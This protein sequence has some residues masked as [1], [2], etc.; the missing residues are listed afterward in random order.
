MLPSTLPDPG[1]NNM[2]VEGSIILNTR[3]IPH[4]YILVVVKIPVQTFSSE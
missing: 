3:T 1:L 4:K 2:P